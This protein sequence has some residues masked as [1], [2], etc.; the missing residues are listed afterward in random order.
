M[1]YG[2][3]MVTRPM[4][5]RDLQRRCQAVRLAILATAWLLV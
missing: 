2:Y 1:A 3:Q 4:T 5:S